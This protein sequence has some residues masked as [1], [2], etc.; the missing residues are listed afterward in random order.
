MCT[1]L[2]P[3]TLLVTSG[4]MNVEVQRGFCKKGTRL[5]IVPEVNVL[6]NKHFILKQNYDNVLIRLK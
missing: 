5:K 6:F 3:V 4:H 1:P 2:S